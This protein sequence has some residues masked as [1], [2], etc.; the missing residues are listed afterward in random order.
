MQP[1]HAV[2]AGLVARVGGH[3]GHITRALDITDENSKYVASF[4]SLLIL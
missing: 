3:N 2:F 1:T 4:F